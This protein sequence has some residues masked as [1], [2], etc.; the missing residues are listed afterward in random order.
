MS[1]MS[2]LW[3]CVGVM[4]LLL[5]SSVKVLSQL[6][7][8]QYTQETLLLWLVDLKLSSICINAENVK[9]LLKRSHLYWDYETSVTQI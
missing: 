3:V 9:K 2:E 6:R 7:H 8:L 5:G 4:V 1:L